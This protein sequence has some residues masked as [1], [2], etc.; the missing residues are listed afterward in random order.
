MRRAIVLAVLC[1]AAT[2]CAGTLS[3][4]GGDVGPTGTRL[5]AKYVVYTRY[6]TGDRYEIWI[7]RIDGG[8][9]RRLA[10]GRSPRISPDGG[11]VVYQGGCD[12]VGDCRRLYLIAST[13]DVGGSWR[14]TAGM[15]AGLRTVGESSSPTEGVSSGSRSRQAGRT[16][17]CAGTCNGA[18]VG[19]SRR[20]ATRSLTPSRDPDA[21]F[22][23]TSTSTSSG[24]AA[25]RR[26]AL[27]PTAVV[28]SLSG[29][30]AGSPL[31]DL[32]ITAA[33]VV[34]RI[35]PD[36]TERRTVTGRTPARLLGH[37]ITSLIPIAWSD[38]SRRLL[39]GL[40]SEF[41]WVPFAVDPERGTMRKIDNYGYADLPDGL[42]RDGRYVLVSVGDVGSYDRTR[43][44]I[45]EYGGGR[46]RVIERRAGEASWNL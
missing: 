40:A 44:E 17:S 26:V 8:G 28:P 10:A 2:G 35:N 36:G 34:W 37:G 18:G 43:V 20:Q 22:T 19:A 46:G 13:G 42:S 29:A 12:P 14:Q 5:D 23:A 27:R 31:R 1:L 24:S 3:G 9:K 15:H 4:G 16:R 11:W 45:V 41:G 30:P 39:A 38:D 25:A 21:A 7:A 33:G 6:L 32:S